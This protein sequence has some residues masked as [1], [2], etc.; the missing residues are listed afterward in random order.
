MLTSF[1]LILTH[2][3]T[4]VKIFIYYRYNAVSMWN[5]IIC[6]LFTKIY[7]KIVKGVILIQALG[8][9]SGLSIDAEYLKVIQELRRLGLT[10]TGNQEV[11]FIRL[12]RAKSELVNKIRDKET[13]ESSESI[14]VQILSPV[15]EAKNAERSQMEAQRL[16][17]MTVAELNKIYFGL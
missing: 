5:Y 8:N 4:F 3:L 10:S 6:K 7:R 2:L 12:E 14:G 1:S 15:D 17:A 9:A 16:G 13:R 11:D